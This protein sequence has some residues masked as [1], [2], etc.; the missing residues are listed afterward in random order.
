[1]SQE[2][3]VNSLAYLHSILTNKNEDIQEFVNKNILAQWP[4]ETRNLL[5]P[6]Y[7]Y[8]SIR[9]K[10]TYI[11]LL[12]KK[13][14]A[15]ISK[16]EFSNYSENSLKNL[17][18]LQHFA[19]NKMIKPL[20]EHFED[21]IENENAEW[22]SYMNCIDKINEIDPQLL[23]NYEEKECNDIQ[24]SKISSR[25]WIRYPAS[26]NLIASIEA[27]RVK[28]IASSIPY[29]P[30]N[31]PK[32]GREWLHTWSRLLFFKITNSSSVDSVR[33]VATFRDDPFLCS[34]YEKAEPSLDLDNIV[35]TLESF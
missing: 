31:S 4:V 9:G 8:V 21:E 26:I 33:Y 1:M 6:P 2:S 17:R 19:L 22:T 16:Q 20:H 24:S 32:T 27:E 28:R 3:Q 7:F 18:L 35:Y 29:I 10:Q 13:F 34:R 15:T 5:E 30:D 14:N 11:Y 25:D 23:I 12:V